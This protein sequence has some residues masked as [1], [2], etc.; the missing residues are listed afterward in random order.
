MDLQSRKIEFIQE[1]LKLQSEE[2]ISRLEKLLKK[3]KI[4]VVEEESKPMTKKELNKRID[5][6]ESDFEKNRF[7]KTSELLSK[8]Q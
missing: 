5:Q 2:A 7:K 6:S 1:F 3:E 8:Y 4:N